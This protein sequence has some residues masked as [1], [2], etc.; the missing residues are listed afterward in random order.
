M[1]RTNR[2]LAVPA[3]ALAAVAA[4]SLPA[5]SFADDSPAGADAAVE[6]QAIPE[7]Y[8]YAALDVGEELKARIRET[9]MPMIGKP[10]PEL[11]LAEFRNSDG[12]TNSDLKGKIV[13]VD[14]WA[15]WCGPCIAAI[16]K[17]NDLQEKY[18]DDGVVILGV[19]SSSGQEKLDETIEKHS[20]AYPVA[21]D[22]DSKTA[23]AWNV[24]FYPTYYAIDRDGIVRGVALQPGKLEDAIKMLLEEQPAPEAEVAAAE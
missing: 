9:L 14:V 7:E 20:I 6:K 21:K 5:A 12:F 22:P 4:F 10:A 8:T 19:C 17:N 15:T 3:L 1:R 16:P 18:A 2:L 11:S 24:S 23:E 13:I